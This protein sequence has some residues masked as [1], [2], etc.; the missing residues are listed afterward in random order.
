MMLLSINFHI[1]L[2]LI[3][4]KNII[5]LF[6][7][8]FT[9][10]ITYTFLFTFIFIFTLYPYFH[11]LSLFSLFIL[12]FFTP[13]SFNFVLSFAL[14]ININSDG[15]QELSNVCRQ[16]FRILNIVQVDPY[17]IADVEYGIQGKKKLIQKNC[18]KFFFDK[19]FVQVYVFIQYYLC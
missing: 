3:C 10:T 2:L 13:F 12:I 5:S 8:I 1:E 4:I 19:M 17:I 14:Y 9:F 15:S 7:F 11:S 16:R 6:T 18:L